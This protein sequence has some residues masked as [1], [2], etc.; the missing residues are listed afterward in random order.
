MIKNSN[1]YKNLSPEQL[2]E[3]FSNFIINSWSYSKCT[4]FARNELGFEMIYI[5]REPIR[6][7]STTIAGNAYHSA[8]QLFFDSKKDKKEVDIIDLEKHVIDYIEKVPVNDWK[9]QKTTPTVEESKKKAVETSIKLVRNFFDEIDIYLE[10]IS[11]ILFVEVKGNEFVS[12]A[13]EEIPLPCNFVIDLVVKTKRNTIAIIDHK[14]KNSFSDDKDVNFSIGVQ[15]I[16]YAIGFEEKTK[17]PVDEVW[18]IE[19]KYSSNRDKSPQLQKNIVELDLNTRR[20]YEMMLY[21]PL[22]RMIDAITNP[23]YIYLMNES[24]NFL[25]KEEQYEFMFRR[26]ISEID[27]FNIDESKRHLI[28][29]RHKKV[30]DSSS[31]TIAPSVIKK[32]REN[33]AT[34]IQY[35]LTHKNMTEKEKIEHVL[36]TFGLKVEV[37]HSF[38]GY[39]SCTHLLEVS[40]GCKVSDIQKYKLDLANQLNVSNVRIPKDLRVYQGKSYVEVEFSKKADSYLSFNESDLIDLK[41]PI[42]KNNLGEIIYLDLDNHSTPHALVCGATGSGKTESLVSTIE[43]AKLAKI[44]DIVILDTKHDFRR[45]NVEG[46][47]IICEIEEIEAKMAELVE[48]MNER[49]KSGVNTKKLIIFDE[50]ADALAQSR[51]GKKLDIYEMQEV[52]FYRQTKEMIEN[53]IPAQPK[54]QKVLIGRDNS[55]E[56]NLRIL[57]QKGR[58]LGFRIIAAT[59]RAS[60]KIITGDAKANFPVQIC[61]YVPK[62]VDSMVV[63]DEAGAELLQGKGDG[64]IKSPEF[65]E[66]VRFQGY[67]FNK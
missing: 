48:E 55:L 4:Q 54:M 60:T 51:Q 64:L 34:F 15:A 41:I 18:F 52:G 6:K 61:F 31:K 29:Q 35:D 42:G 17:M 10:D 38:E 19:N 3:H 23:N 66:L 56:E 36:R 40:F 9:I 45:R 14:S 25:D 62:A 63:L 24:D 59:Q 11:E 39:S 44:N 49:V 46:A 58:S 2:E 32:F 16:T 27:D 65:K 20:I 30:R 67:F 37:A 26:M 33:A 53:G 43:Y 7:S 57:L 47:E 21:E 50:F 5:Y 28:S 8:L 22:S 12:V 1:S 13:G